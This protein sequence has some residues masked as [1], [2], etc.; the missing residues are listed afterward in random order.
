MAELGGPGLVSYAGVGQGIPLA[1]LPDG[2]YVLSSLLTNLFVVDG[3]LRSTPGLELD[4]ISSIPDIGGRKV[5]NIFVDAADMLKVQY[6][7]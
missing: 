3:T 7:K 2:S 4:R 5:V 6:D 1:L